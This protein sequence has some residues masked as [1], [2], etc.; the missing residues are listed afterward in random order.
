MSRSARTGSATSSFPRSCTL[1]W[2]STVSGTSRR[3]GS[4]R[5]EGCCARS[6]PGPHTPS[7]WTQDGC[8]A[9]T[10]GAAGWRPQFPRPGAFPPQIV[11]RPQ[12]PVLCAQVRPARE[13]ADDDRLHASE[14]PGDLRAGPTTALLTRAMLTFRLLIMIRARALFGV[15]HEFNLVLGVVGCC[16]TPP[17]AHYG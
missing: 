10:W 7:A 5:N 2:R 6:W 9:S 3:S 11:A 8:L 17:R 4:F 15:S 14:R 13:P 16:L 1:S 12:G